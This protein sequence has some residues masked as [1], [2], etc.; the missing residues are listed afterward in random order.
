MRQKL[1]LLF[2]ITA[3][4]FAS[5]TSCKKTTD[6]RADYVSFYAVTETWPE[7]GKMLTKSVF[8]M[9]VYKSSISSNGLLLENFANYGNGIVVEAIVSGNIITIPRQVL[10]NSR[11]IVGTGSINNNGTLTFTYTEI[12]GN[13]SNSVSATAQ[14]K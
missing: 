11:T 14:K 12:Y 8:F 5:M 6:D 7:N 1:F 9:P 2:V 3:I 4:T 13:F 10:P